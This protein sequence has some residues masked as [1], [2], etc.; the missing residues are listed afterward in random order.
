MKA[1]LIA[2]SKTPALTPLAQVTPAPLLPLLGAPLLFPLLQ[3]MA[4]SGIRDVMLVCATRGA[5]Y[6]RV[7]HDGR[8][9]GLNLAVVELG[10]AAD[11]VSQA[12]GAARSRG[13]FDETLVVLPA[14][15]WTAASWARAESL[16]HDAG[17]RLSRLF[18]EGKPTDILL[19]DP[20]VELSS[21]PWTSLAMEDLRYRPV[22][23]WPEYWT[24]A[25]D[26][27]EH[28]HLGIAPR[29]DRTPGGGAL[30]GPLAR[31]D[32]QADCEGPVWLGPDARVHAGAVLR[33]PVW[34]G[35]GCHVGPG[36]RLE[37]CAIEAGA[38]LHGPLR[39]TQALVVANRAIDLV[40]GEVA[41]LDERGY[42]P[43]EEHDSSM[44][45]GLLQ[46]ATRTARR[47]AWSKTE[48]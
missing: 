47:E 26:A 5:A 36:V 25:A 32:S 44:S 11:S 15:C 19:A 35:A 46:L 10:D 4:R 43:A 14:N 41:V 34:I 31:I 28:P 29:Y 17:G 24:L 42:E 40:Q 8:A 45:L 12:V 22:R 18:D 21:A 3:R 23:S 39:L 38:R 37:S 48:A 7:L 30:C 13:F 27:L 16:H 9:W 2:G 20:G 33:G 1:L 6:T